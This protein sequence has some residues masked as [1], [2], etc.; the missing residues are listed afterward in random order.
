MTT[1]ND[2]EKKAEQIRKEL[3]LED[4]TNLVAQAIIDLVREK[5]KLMTYTDICNKIQ[6]YLGLEC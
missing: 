1:V 4:K 6:T 2:L 5:K 3:F